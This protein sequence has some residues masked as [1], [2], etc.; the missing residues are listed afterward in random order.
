MKLHSK[1]IIILFTLN[2][3]ISNSI[4]TNIKIDT[5]VDNKIITNFEISK[6][7]RYL[8]ILNPNLN[9]LSKKQIYKLAKQSL[10][11]EIIKK[12]EIIRFV[13][14]DDNNLVINEYYSN[15]IL[16]LGYENKKKF[17]ED[18]KFNKTYSVEEIKSK[19]KIEFYWNELVFNKFSNQINV[20]ENK[21][22]KKIDKLANK[23][24]N[25]YFLSEI[26][27]KKQKDENIMDTKTKIKKAI[28]EIGFGNTANL[29]SISD[30]AK[31]AGKIGWVDESVLSEKIYEEIKLL[32][33]N[34]ISKPIKM[35][36]S[37]IILKIED[38][39]IIKN[40]IDKKT[41]LIKLIEIERN[42]KL[43][44]FS[45]IYF[46]KVKKNYSINEK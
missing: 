18:L 3:T 13:N 38:I 37:F 27:F 11:K 43:E 30:S 34:Q 21:L 8:K 28:S 23:S 41:E 36:N 19:I 24:T 4:A 6:E 12:D 44:K 26:V 32:K 25:S 31:F 15:L 39:K 9:N 20:N 2:F 17:E 40:K 46:N 29:Y 22:L 7:A 35:V 5:L 33:V 1:L 10:I 14:L 45:R 16:R 42:K